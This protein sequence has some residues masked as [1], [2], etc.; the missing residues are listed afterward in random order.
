MDDEL[1]AEADG[2][3]G[4]ALHM[5]APE[6]AFSQDFGSRWNTRK[7]EI[8]DL[9]EDHLLASWETSVRKVIQAKLAYDKEMEKAMQ[10]QV[11]I[12]WLV[13]G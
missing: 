13:M 1:I 6:L 9:S 7:R 2:S 3:L 8:L 5:T 10:V 12:P 11:S 4:E